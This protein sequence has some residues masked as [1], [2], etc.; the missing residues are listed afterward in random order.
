MRKEVFQQNKN[1]FYNI[2][3]LSNFTILILFSYMTSVFHNVAKGTSYELLTFLIAAPVLLAIILFIAI[4]VVGKEQV[5][6]ELE[7]LLT[8]SKN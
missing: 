5:I 3:I 6:K 8:G 1:K 4:F 7:E 2:L